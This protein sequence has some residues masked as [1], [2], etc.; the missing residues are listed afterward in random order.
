MARPPKYK[1]EEE[2]R[3]AQRLQKRR[4]ASI[5]RRRK[6]GLPDEAPPHATISSE[7][8]A[9]HKLTPEQ[10]REIRRLHAA[11]NWTFTT[12]ARQFGVSVQTISAIVRG[13]SWKNTEELWN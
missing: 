5:L 2:R 6:A 4:S 13:E 10:V 3:E 1:S 11:E 8:G 12:L 9:G 7:R